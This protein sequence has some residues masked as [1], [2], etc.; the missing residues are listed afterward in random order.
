[1]RFQ[2]LFYLSKTSVNIVEGLFLH[3]SLNAGYRPS[4]IEA[5]YS[6]RLFSEILETA[7]DL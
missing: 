3:E 7:A 2:T 5:S 1:M 6:S 4:A